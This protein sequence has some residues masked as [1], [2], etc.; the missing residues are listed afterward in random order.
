MP[1]SVT[2]SSVRVVE[3]WA[4][5]PAR[6]FIWSK[7]ASCPGCY[8]SLRPASTGSWIAEGWRGGGESSGV[9]VWGL[10][11]LFRGGVNLM[12]CL[13]K[14]GN[15]VCRGRCHTRSGSRSLSCQRLRGH[16]TA[17]NLWSGP[18]ELPLLRTVSRIETTPTF[19]WASTHAVNIQSQ[20]Y[21]HNA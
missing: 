8:E 1:A 7:C 14:H 19:L 13:I 20:K 9:E 15:L 6:L 21:S 10:L 3:L 12:S 5:A 18:L 11:H 4:A 16:R 17:M 2:A